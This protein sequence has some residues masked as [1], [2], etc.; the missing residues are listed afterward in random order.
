MQSNA[1]ARLRSE[2]MEIQIIKIFYHYVQEI[3]Q[4]CPALFFPK[5]QRQIRVLGLL[6]AVR[7]SASIRGI[8]ATR[9]FGRRLCFFHNLGYPL[10]I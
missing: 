6:T 8:D 3:L 10:V 2:R 5:L 7:S 9:P 1:R 4:I